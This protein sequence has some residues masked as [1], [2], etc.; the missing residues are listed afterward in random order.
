MKPFLAPATRRTKSLFPQVMGGILAASVLLAPRGAW[1]VSPS[2]YVTLDAPLASQAAGRGTVAS[3]V[4]GSNV[5]G[6]YQDAALVYHGFL[7]NSGSYTVIDHP[8]AGSTL[9]YGTQITGIDGSNIVG[10]VTGPSLAK[11]FLY[12]GSTFTDIVFPGASETRVTAI[13]GSS[14]AGQYVDALGTHA[15]TFDGSIWKTLKVPSPRDT[16]ATGVS[17]SNVVGLYSDASGIFHGFLYNGSTYTTLDAPTAIQVNGLGTYAN[18]IS[19]NVIVGLFQDDSTG[20]GFLY[21]GSSWITLDAPQASGTEAKDIDGSRIV[22]Y[23]Y[24][25]GSRQHGF[26][27]TVPEPT[28]LALVVAAFSMAR[29]KKAKTSPA[30]RWATYEAATAK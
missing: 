8:S 30:F 22:G 3:S 24:G 15:F 14:L 29:R 25:P 12:D 27:L 11:S 7:Y 4:S 16:Y 5:V 6:Y 2:N 17:G 26:L 18:G 28:S 20:H 9:G 1:A 21:D 13:S 10:M 19:G 23:F